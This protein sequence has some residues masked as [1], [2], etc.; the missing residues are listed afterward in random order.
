MYLLRQ[1]L[2]SIVLILG[3][4][5]QR[6][7]LVEVGS[8]Q[9]KQEADDAHRTGVF[10]PYDD[11]YRNGQKLA[12]ISND[13]EGS[14]RQQRS[15]APR[16][17]RHGR[18]QHHTDADGDRGR[19][20]HAFQRL[21]LRLIT[22]KREDEG[23]TGQQV[24]VVHPAPIGIH[25]DAADHVLEVDLIQTKHRVPKGA[26]G[27]SLDLEGGVGLGVA[28]GTDEEGDEADPRPRAGELPA[29]EEVVG[30]ADAKGGAEPEDHEGLDV[31]ILER[32][33][34]EEDGAEED[35]GD[36]EE[37][38][39]LGLFQAVALD[40]SEGLGGLDDDGRAG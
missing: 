24:G 10:V 15:G 17:V 27:V 36:G 39:G 23:R 14:G 1:Q 8:T 22:G 30:N 6:S 16:K 33:D 20:V 31:G 7:L 40:V 21:H 11:I 2:L 25:L 12:Y 28:Q 32:F 35:E 29:Q 13:R 34:V 5:S 3:L 4:C 37:F 19:H 38:E 9:T 18:T 26:E